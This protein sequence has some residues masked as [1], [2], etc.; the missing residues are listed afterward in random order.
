MIMP[1]YFDT[2]PDV[3]Y[4]HIYTFLNPIETYITHTRN[5]QEREVLLS[6][7][8]NLSKYTNRI[9]VDTLNNTIDIETSIRMLESSNELMIDAKKLNMV[10][11]KIADFYTNNTKYQRPLWY[12]NLQVWHFIISGEFTYSDSQIKRM[13]RNIRIMRYKTINGGDMD[14]ENI[15]DEDVV[16]CEIVE[17][18]NKAGKR[19][20]RHCCYRNG[21]RNLDNLSHEQLR[22]LLINI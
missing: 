9:A 18:L 12:D 8:R 20:L 13:E 7:I 3:I 10:L 14:D 1:S 11:H 21:M 15:D 4:R 16:Y 5:I 19:A 22:K 2:L 6:N 17:F